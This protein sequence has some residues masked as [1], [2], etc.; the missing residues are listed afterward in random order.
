MD[1]GD[2]MQSSS[3]NNE[4]YDSRSESIS[5]FLNSSGHMS[6]PQPPPPHPSHPHNH[7][8]PSSFFDPL[9][10]YLDAFPRSSPN[11]NANSLLIP[12]MLW[13]RA[14][15]SEPNCTEIGGLMGSLSS[16]QP[17][18]GVQGPGRSLYP[19]TS[20]MPPLP[21]GSENGGRISATSDQTNVVRNNSKKRSRA[22]R[23]APTTV[24]T[25]DTS[26]FRAMVQE[27]TGIPAPPFS[28][29]SFPRARFDLFPSSSTMRSSH[30]MEPPSPY[31][32]RHF[33]QKMVPSFATSTMVD[34]INASTTKLSNTTSPTSAVP[35]TSNSTST[36]INYQLLSDLGLPN[37]QSQNIQNPIL[38]FQSLQQSHN[39][40]PPPKYPSATVPVFGAKS[41]GP[42]SIPPTD[43]RLKMAVLEEFGMGHGHLSGVQSLVPYDGMSLRSGNNPSNWG[44]ND[45]DQGHL[46]SFNGI[47]GNSQRP[48]GC[49]MNYSASSSDF[50][51]QKGSESVSSRGEG[52]LDSWICSSD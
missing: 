38:T 32:L 33:T 35:D 3:G 25:T 52:M 41:Q 6:N 48:S 50:H 24:L 27:F 42:S 51:G 18:T 22:S 39:S 7:N 5:T 17:I 37:K 2:S 46:K 12:D 15:R 36:N 1:S 34:A 11:P 43:S 44:V 14:P 23:R 4:E 26:N 49:K 20:S 9:S 31:L 29:L 28:A 47:Y 8:H 16:I 13:S 40:L 21:I 30:L 45:G 10:N 19:S